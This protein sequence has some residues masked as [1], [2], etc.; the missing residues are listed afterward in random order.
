MG[1]RREGDHVVLDDHVGLE[2]FEDLAQP[3]IGVPR[4]VGEC[5]EGRLDELSELFEGLLAKDR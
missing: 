3:L 1:D 5:T 2:L 4:T